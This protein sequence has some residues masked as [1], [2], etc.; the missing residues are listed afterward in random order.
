MSW[1]NRGPSAPSR[2]REHRSPIPPSHRSEW[3]GF[4]LSFF[5]L[6]CIVSVGSIFTFPCEPCTSFG[7]TYDAR[8]KQSHLKL[9][10]RIQYYFF[11]SHAKSWRCHL[12]WIPNNHRISRTI[13]STANAIVISNLN[14][15]SRL[16]LTLSS[17]SIA[18]P[19]H[20]RNRLMRHPHWFVP[21]NSMICK[22]HT[23]HYILRNLCA[24]F[25]PSKCQMSATHSLPQCSTWS[26][27]IFRMPPRA[28]THTRE[29]R[30]QHRI[31]PMASTT[32]DHILKKLIL[33]YRNFHAKCTHSNDDDDG[34]IEISQTFRFSL[35]HTTRNHL[36]T[37]K[38]RY[39]CVRASGYHGVKRHTTWIILYT[40][41][42][43]T[44]H[45]VYV[46]LN[47]MSS[48]IP[49]FVSISFTHTHTHYLFSS[50]VLEC[51][52]NKR[53]K[54]ETYRQRDKSDR[55]RWKKTQKCDG[56]LVWFSVLQLK[57]DYCLLGLQRRSLMYLC[58]IS[59]PKLVLFFFFAFIFMLFAIKIK[60]HSYMEIGDRQWQRDHPAEYIFEFIF[61]VVSKSRD[62]DERRR[63]SRNK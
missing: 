46:S 49:M 2:S 38:Q 43:N 3:I 37:H 20:S 16:L 34:T 32:G 63:R 54:S 62:K 31:A 57:N 21:W 47:H 40:W 61:F 51:C 9:N 35:R 25:P 53:N 42:V 59:T 19:T 48:F 7:G 27:L 29:T 58:R 5:L 18:H 36:A 44:E 60:W 8:H 39:D 45:T 30:N 12:K 6:F 15:F 26:H 55:K 23:R 41:Q 11:I 56:N 50:V 22:E 24:S 4:C 1:N 17:S 10:A 28:R 14:L 13:H 52:R 33:I